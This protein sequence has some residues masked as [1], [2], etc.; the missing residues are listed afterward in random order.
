M[1]SLDY[2]ILRKARFK[3]KAYVSRC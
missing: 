1:K 2:K 3:E